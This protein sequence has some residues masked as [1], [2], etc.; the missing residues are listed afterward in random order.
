MTPCPWNRLVCHW[1]DNTGGVALEY[2]LIAAGI[3]MAIFGSL[4]LIGIEVQEIFL[5]FGDV[6]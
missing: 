2:A 3:A 5:R 6:F 4:R 1:R